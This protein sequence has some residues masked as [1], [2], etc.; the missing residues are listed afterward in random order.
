MRAPIKHIWFD[1]AG[2]LYR[3][4]D[5]FSAVHDQYRYHTYARLRGIMDPDRAR[6]E[7]LALYKTHGSNS[8][9][10]RSLG[11]PSNY[12]MKALEEMDFSA[13]LK[14]DKNITETLKELNRVVPISLFTNFPKARIDEILGIIE[15]P[16]DLFMHVLSGDD[17]AERKPALDGFYAMIKRSGLPGENLLYVG[18]R[19]EVDIKPAKQLGIQTCLVWGYSHEADY[20]CSELD[21]LWPVLKGKLRI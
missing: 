15:I 5:E 6:Q 2:T 7:Y 19:V 16:A 9:V 11:Q 18:D 14:P 1:L 12:W 4:T 17:I 10:F 13:V 20:S 8:A 21:G 3:E